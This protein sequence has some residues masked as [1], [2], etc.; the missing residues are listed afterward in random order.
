MTTPSP[1]QRAEWRVVFDASH[2]I[3][4]STNEPSIREIIVAYYA[5]HFLTPRAKKLAD[6]LIRA[7]LAAARGDGG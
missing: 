7:S 5:A 1:Q 3:G 2:N 4:A 6:K